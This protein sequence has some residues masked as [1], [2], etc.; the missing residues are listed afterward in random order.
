MSPGTGSISSVGSST[1]LVIFEFNARVKE[2]GRLAQVYAKEIVSI[3]I[4]FSAI[5]VFA[6]LFPESVRP[7]YHAVAGS[8][9]VTGTNFEEK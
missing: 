5:R 9:P 7:F 2:I 1:G 3:V 8:S 6:Y 4:R